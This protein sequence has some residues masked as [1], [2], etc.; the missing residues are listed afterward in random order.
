MMMK[1]QTRDDRVRALSDECGSVAALHEMMSGLAVALGSLVALEVER[2]D[3]LRGARR[4][5]DGWREAKLALAWATA[6]SSDAQARA[7]AA[8]HERDCLRRALSR[9]RR[10]VKQLRRAVLAWS[11]LSGFRYVRGESAEHFIGRRNAILARARDRSH[12]DV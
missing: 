6:E 5:R 12:D 4:C 3:I 1:R 9:E 11:G 7:I 2:V 10:R 8:E